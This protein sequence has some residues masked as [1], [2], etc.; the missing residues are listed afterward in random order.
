[1][2]ISR[3]QARGYRTVFCDHLCLLW[4]VKPA[5][6]AF[7]TNNAVCQNCQNTDA[8][9]VSRSCRRHFCRNLRLWLLGVSAAS[10]SKLALCCY[11]SVACVP[12]EARLPGP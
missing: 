8:Q 11:R 12:M 6:S 2:D 10:D 7:T 4:G 1:M 5:P 9:H 3:T